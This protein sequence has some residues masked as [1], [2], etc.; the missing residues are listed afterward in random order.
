MP[1]NIQNTDAAE[2]KKAADS[3][4]APVEK[5]KA[6]D[7]AE[8]AEEKKTAEEAKSAEGA[9]GAAEGEDAGKTDEDKKALKRKRFKKI[10][11]GV[12]IFF[13]VVFLLLVLVLIFRDP[14]LVVSV[15]QIGSYLTGT[16]VNV[17][18]ID[19]SLVNGTL[20]VAN[21]SLDNPQG[22]SDKKA[23]ELG[24][25][26]VKLEPLSVFTK[27]I[28][29][30]DININALN[31]SCEYGGKNFLDIY[32][33]IQKKTGSSKK[34]KKADEK[35]SE[36]KVVIRHLKLEKS[37]LY[38]DVLPLPINIELNNIGGESGSTWDELKES[39]TKGWSSTSNSA[40][41]FFNSIFK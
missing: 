11:R 28:I 39:C 36:T 6:A 26:Y 5:T 30:E 27:K 1:E 34:K 17:E 29:V 16:K 24:S 21:F 33:H 18:D 15:R 3:S 41:G 2:E 25:L 9:E 40:K 13:A 23:V 35:P 19:T 7:G 10:M 22:Y 37:T 8:A 12:G 14:I 31:I 20:R 32:D 4:E 38:L